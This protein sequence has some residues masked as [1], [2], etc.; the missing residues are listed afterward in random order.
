MVAK[1]A[2][3][4]VNQVTSQAERAL[5]NQLVNAEVE[6]E[7]AAIDGMIGL[8]ASCC[9]KPAI[10]VPNL[11]AVGAA[12]G[13]AVGNAVGKAAAVGVNQVLSNAQVKMW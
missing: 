6:A 10:K 7:A 8:F 4:A 2:S 11:N 3:K 13:N 1:Q 9:A 12:A 5:E